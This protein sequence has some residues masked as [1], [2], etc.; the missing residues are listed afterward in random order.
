M[1]Y[2]V[3]G[4]RAQLI[5]MASVIA[6][7]EEKGW[8]LRIIHTGQ[9]MISMDDLRED[10]SL[11]TPWVYLIKKTEAKTVFS[12]LKWLSHI[13]YLTAFRAKELIPN[14]NKKKDIVLVHGDTFSTVI[15]ALLGKLS[16]ASVGH[17]ESGL[18][19]FNVLHPFPEEINR[20][21]TFRLMDVAFCPGEWAK[22]N[23]KYLKRK[24]II[25]TVNNTL[26]D[27]LVLALRPI[28]SPS[29]CIKLK[30]Y[31]VISIHRFENLYSNKR[32]KTI[33]D[34]ILYT[35]NKIPVTFVMHPITKKRLEK[36]GLIKQLYSHRNIT[37]SPRT[38]YFKFIELIAF[39]SFVIT[40]G[41]SNQEELSYLNIPTLLVRKTTERQEGLT[42]N[43]TLSN[44]SVAISTNFIDLNLKNSALS[45]NI[46][47]QKFD[48]PTDKILNILEKFNS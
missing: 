9:H 32:L 1:I 47:I 3:I 33:I 36:T 10:F 13:L 2:C 6:A 46:S 18:R 16:G 23:L 24:K 26:Y 27:S 38:G 34:L 35:A 31:A 40:D 37:L 28:S 17:V 20:L 22:Q 29:N 39:S 14:A 42:T 15:G 8:P 11:Q 41:G 43:V 19:S 12:S 21:I 7:I 45:R 5:K 48:S 44:Y 4:T 30:N 25:N